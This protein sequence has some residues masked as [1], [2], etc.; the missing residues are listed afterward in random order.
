LEFCTRS[1][2]LADDEQHEKRYSGEV[3]AWVSTETTVRF[4]L[5]G[6]ELTPPLFG[7]GPALDA[8]K[9]APSPCCSDPQHFESG[10]TSVGTAL[11][12]PQPYDQPSHQ[13]Y[14]AA[15]RLHLAML[16]NYEV[17]DAAV[18]ADQ[19][20]RAKEVAEGTPESPSDKA[21][22]QLNKNKL[23]TADEAAVKSE[24]GMET[25]R[26]QVLK[27]AKRQSSALVSKGS[28][29]CWRFGSDAHS[30]FDERAAILNQVTCEQSGS[31]SAIFLVFY[32]F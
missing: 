29:R 4:C 27:K 16:E 32:G 5:P 1:W 24:H 14:M 8:R 22:R 21:Q 6:C 28:W 3:S 12:G 9:F 25:L 31:V 17:Q 7:G 20:N 13:R 23:K 2:V 30:I 11:H 26:K 10:S 15:E 18:E 19:V